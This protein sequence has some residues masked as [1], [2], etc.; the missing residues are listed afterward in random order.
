MVVKEDPCD[1]VDT[2]IYCNSFPAGWILSVGAFSAGFSDV[3]ILSRNRG[4]NGARLRTVELM[5]QKT[6]K[7]S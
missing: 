6:L 5:E 4:H 7:V 1:D 2:E 3:M